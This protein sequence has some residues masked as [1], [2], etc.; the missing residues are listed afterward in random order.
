MISKGRLSLTADELY[1]R[2]SG[3]EILKRYLG[4]EYVPSLIHSPLRNDE[5]RSFSLFTKD[6]GVVLFK[7]H[8]S[9]LSGDTVMLLSMLWNCSREEAVNRIWNEC[10]CSSRERVSLHQPSVVPTSIQFKTRNWEQHDIDFWGKYG[11]TMPWLKKARII[12]I[13]HFVLI[14]GSNNVIFKADEYAYVFYSDNGVKIYQPYSVTAK[15]FS[16]QKGGN[17][18]LFDCLPQFGDIVCVCSSMKD[19][20]CLWANT[21]IPSIAPQSEGISLPLSVVQD[22][23]LRFTHRY[24]MYDNDIAGIGYAKEAAKETG[25]T[26][27]L[28]PKF[29]G[30]KDISDY[31]ESLTDKKDFQK[32][33]ELFNG[34]YNQK[35]AD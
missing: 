29:E 16:T 15:W 14:K 10:N 33:K 19:A 8:S 21:G 32:I 35:D 17:V 28:L 7:D 24:I 34:N 5:H 20:L 27:V 12:P 26:N 13:S 9:G 31:Y 18:Q 1:Q 2:I 4:V 6:N 25:F 30:G 23:N 22:L 11:I 3:E